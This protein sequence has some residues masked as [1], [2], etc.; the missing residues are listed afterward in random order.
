[1]TELQGIAR[2]RILPGKLEDFRR[3]AEAC[4]ESVKTKDTGTLQYEVYLNADG[5]EAVVLER[6]RDSAALLEH[7]W[8]LGPL[9][10]QLL[11]VSTVTGELCG[12]PNLPLKM[13]V[14]GAGVPIYAPLLYWNFR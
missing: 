2:I 4:L 11:E 3:L 14:E 7:T 9:M 5:T 13:A 1:M 6:Y 8:N 12:S 10:H